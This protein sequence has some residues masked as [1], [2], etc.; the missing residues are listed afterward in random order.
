MNPAFRAFHEELIDY[1]GLFPPA[2][3]E[4]PAALANYRTYWASAESWMLARF[5][6]PIPRLAKLEEVCEAADTAPPKRLAVLARPAES[7]DQLLE[8]MRDDLE[9][10]EGF[11]ERAGTQSTAEVLELRV[12]AKLKE[13]PALLREVRGLL[14]RD[15]L[16]PLEIFVEATPERHMNEVVARTV[17]AL[18][19]LRG[20]G[21]DAAG[22]KL[23]C[24]GV[25]A[26]A[27]PAVETVKTALVET[28]R[29]GVPMK[30]TAGL[31]HPVRHHRDDLGVDEHGF[32]NLFGGG[33]LLAAGVIDGE[34][35]ED[36]L[37]ETDPSRF[38][39]DGGRF[40]WNDVSAG[41]EAIALGRRQALTSFGSCS[42]D[43][44]REDLIAL[45]HEL[46]WE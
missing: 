24:G 27:Y 39:F 21:W 4:L 20:E 43:E 28:H 11:L 10:L 40:S 13:A 31:H 22:F 41:A 42:F 29:H 9:N 16:P 8:S 1:A 2:E 23:R 6:C 36:V 25:I 32:W 30:A 37:R 5:V 19:Q 15:S 7:S 38:S 14:D 44:P 46:S 45:G 34:L 18:G 26:A 17:D 3:L 12:P 33:L 35:L